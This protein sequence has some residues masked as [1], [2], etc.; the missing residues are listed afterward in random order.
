MTKLINIVIVRDATSD[1]I[2]CKTLTIARYKSW[3]SIA[4]REH[5]LVRPSLLHTPQFVIN[6]V[7]VER[8]FRAICFLVMFL[9]FSPQF[10]FVN[11]FWGC[12]GCGSEA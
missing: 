6:D 11:I 4:S 3:M 9:Q 10:R 1:I 12:F 5:L 8:I 2:E 7:I